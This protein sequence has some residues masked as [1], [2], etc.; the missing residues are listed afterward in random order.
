MLLA[1]FLNYLIKKAIYCIAKSVNFDLDIVL[2][3][4]I[5]EN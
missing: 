1:F 4:E 5:F 2:K 3:V